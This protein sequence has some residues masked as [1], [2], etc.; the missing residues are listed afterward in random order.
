M[1]DLYYKKLHK[2]WF[3]SFLEIENIEP[4]IKELIELRD[5]DVKKYYIN[6]YYI[7]ILKDDIGDRAPLLS[8]YIKSTGLEHKFQRL[9]FSAYF[10][11]AEAAHI[12]TYDPKYCSVSLNIPLTDCAGSYTAWYATDK[13]TLFDITTTGRDPVKH[14]QT[15]GQH[16]A[17]LPIDEV[18]EICRVETTRPMLVNTTVLHRGIVPGPSRTIVGIRFNSE[19]TNEEV[20]RL[21]VE[22]PFTQVD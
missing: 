7:N 20:H 6:K 14:G 15:I 17:Y 12:D 21:G 13:N 10:E 18:E 16:F 19:L 4:L 3:Y 1:S 9:L 5:S 11:T 22:Q 2:D 8:A